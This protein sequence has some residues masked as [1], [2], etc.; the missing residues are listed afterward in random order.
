[1]MT[2]SKQ[3]KFTFNSLLEDIMG[4]KC[5]VIK[6]RQNIFFLCVLRP[7]LDYFTFQD[8]FAHIKMSQ[9]VS[10]VKTGDLGLSHM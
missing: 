3:M 6:V 8:Y 1:M 2:L 10:G 4:S 9:S 7:Y 5:S